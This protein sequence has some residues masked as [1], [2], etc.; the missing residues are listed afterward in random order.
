MFST[1]IYAF[2]ISKGKDVSIVQYCLIMGR[3]GL[4]PAASKSM[5]IQHIPRVDGEGVGR[6][7]GSDDGDEDGGGGRGWEPFIVT[8][9][10]CVDGHL[11]PFG[12]RSHTAFDNMAVSL[13]QGDV[14]H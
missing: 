6:G 1:S 12:V 11:G 9:Q 2:G 5:W 8:T 4:I 3:G 10:S 13:I 14:L 7:G